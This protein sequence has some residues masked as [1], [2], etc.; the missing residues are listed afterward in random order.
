[1]CALM[2]IIHLSACSS[3]TSSDPLAMHTSFQF[4]LYQTTLHHK[5]GD[6]EI[7]SNK[8]LMVS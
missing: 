1:M 2:H 8:S 4:A 5:R 3:Q 7:Q 6:A